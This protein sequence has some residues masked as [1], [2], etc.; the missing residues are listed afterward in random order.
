MR[1]KHAR[2]ARLLAPAL[3]PMW[4]TAEVVEAH[5]IEASSICNRRVVQEA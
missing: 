1:S 5:V 2:A 4:M 3:R